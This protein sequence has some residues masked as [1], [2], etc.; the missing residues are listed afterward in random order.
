LG[1]ASSASVSNE[2]PPLKKTDEYADYIY[3]E[4]GGFTKFGY[5]LLTLGVLGAMGL[6]VKKV[7]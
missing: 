7:W 1:E 6:G 2:E 3:K 5:M 4:S